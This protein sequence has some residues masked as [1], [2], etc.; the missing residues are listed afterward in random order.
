MT[1]LE[2]F[3]L[4]TAGLITG[5]ALVYTLDLYVY[6]DLFKELITKCGEPCL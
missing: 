2:R 4:V 3:L 6:Q 5:A 1:T